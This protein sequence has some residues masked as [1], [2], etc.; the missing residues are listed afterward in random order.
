MKTQIMSLA[1]VDAMFTGDVVLEV[2]SHANRYSYKKHSG[3]SDT[4]T[5]RD[6]FE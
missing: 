5:Q 2:P 6:E 4:Q 1:S 3:S